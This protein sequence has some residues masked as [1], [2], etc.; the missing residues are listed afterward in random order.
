MHTSLN[1]QQNKCI[2]QMGSLFNILMFYDILT[3][4]ITNMKDLYGRK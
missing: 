4:Y 3:S 2:L 1:Q